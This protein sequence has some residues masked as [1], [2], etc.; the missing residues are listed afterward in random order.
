MWRDGEGK[1]DAAGTPGFRAET[2]ADAQHLFAK[3][4]QN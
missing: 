3:W 1:R 4:A 2:E